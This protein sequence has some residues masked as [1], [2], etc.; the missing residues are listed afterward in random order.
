MAASIIQAYGA[1][2]AASAQEQAADDALDFYQR[3]Y[4]DSVEAFAPYKEVGY[5]ALGQLSD[6]LLGYRP[7]SLR[8]A[9][10]ET[11]DETQEYKD[12]K[13]KLDATPEYLDSGGWEKMGRE[14][15]FVKGERRINP[16][17]ERLSEQLAETE[18]YELPAQDTT[19]GPDYSAYFQTPGYEF[20]RD[21]GLRDIYQQ[22]AAA[23]PTGN[24]QRAAQQYATGLAS[25]YYENYVN[26]LAG[27]AGVGQSATTS[28]ANLGQSFG[29]TG[30]D[31]MLQRGAAKASGYMG[32]ANAISGGM[33][34]YQNAALYLTGSA[35]GGA[36]QYGGAAA[37][38]YGGCRIAQAVYGIDNPRWTQFFD[39]L[40][41]K[42]P[43]WFRDWYMENQDRVAERVRHEPETKAKI[44]GVMDW[45]IEKEAA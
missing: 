39:F 35:M 5:G 40:H 22:G 7:D 3:I 8:R 4:E 12:L 42:A 13:A 19:G 29:Q 37:A 31:L 27:L 33:R 15:V 2:K 9:L 23:G 10:G 1:S 18:R 24:D 34:Y 28:V 20:I 6:L 25:T 21:E 38:A 32:V 44:Q 41:T 45:I 11:G 30:A 14:E 17:Y 36:S 43:E 26:R 16:E